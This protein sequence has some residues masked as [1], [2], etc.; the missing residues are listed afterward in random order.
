M[1]P[2]MREFHA[3]DQEQERRTREIAERYRQAN[4]AD[5]ERLRDELKTAVEAHFKVR[6]ERREAELKRLEEQLDRLRKTVQLHQEKSAEVINRRVE[7]LLGED[8]LEF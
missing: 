7:Q 8:G 5:R 2:A 6:Q 3:K 4:G 1:D